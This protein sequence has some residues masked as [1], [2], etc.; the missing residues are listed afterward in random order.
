MDKKKYGMMKN[1]QT[2]GSQKV[3]GDGNEGHGRKDLGLAKFCWLESRKVLDWQPGDLG[4]ASSSVTVF[5]TLKSPLPFF[6][7]NFSTNS[8]RRLDLPET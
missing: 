8:V 4:S 1:K 7:P 6:G 3:K 5:V 2:I